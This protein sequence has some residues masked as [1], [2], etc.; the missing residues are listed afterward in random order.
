MGFGHDDLKDMEGDYKDNKKEA[1]LRELQ[2][3]ESHVQRLYKAM[4]EIKQELDFVHQA[5]QKMDSYM[6]SRVMSKDEKIPDND[7][8]VA[9]IH[10][11]KGKLGELSANIKQMKLHTKLMK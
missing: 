2:D 11:L 3:R 1:V 5:I 6:R 4:E 9:E 8:F 10:E 7:P